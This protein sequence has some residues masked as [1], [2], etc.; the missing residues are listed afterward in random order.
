MSI[1]LVKPIGASRAGIE[2]LGA[3]L[4][5]KMD[6]KNIFDFRTR[7][8]K[9][10]GTV[11]Y[12]S[13]GHQTTLL[14]QAYG[15]HDFQVFLSPHFTLQHDD[16]KMIRAL[17]HVILHYPKFSEAYPNTVFTIPRVLATEDEDLKRLCWE[18]V[19]F[20]NAFWEAMTHKIAA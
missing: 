8:E 12:P 19:W 9:M 13:E 4:A 6:I 14:L 11:D 17:G 3:D 15:K 5:V 1:D 10:G 7:F 18:V 2:K 20:Q 16:K